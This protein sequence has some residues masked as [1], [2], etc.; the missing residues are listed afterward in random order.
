M[1]EREG[2]SRLDRAGLNLDERTISLV[3]AAT[4]V[5]KACVISVSDMCYDLNDQGE[6]SIRISTE[7]AGKMAIAIYSSLVSPKTI[8]YEMKDL[9]EQDQ[10]EAEQVPGRLG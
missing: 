4:E 10:N 6:D 2:A 5:M 8:S 3:E 7:S 1:S 9:E